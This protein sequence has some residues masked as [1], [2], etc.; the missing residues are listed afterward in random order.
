MKFISTDSSIWCPP[1]KLQYR[2]V[3]ETMIREEGEEDEEEGEVEETVEE[4]TN[5]IEERKEIHE[6][7]QKESENKKEL[8]LTNTTKD[9]DLGL[10]IPLFM[11]GVDCEMCYTEL[12]LEL[13]R[14]IEI[15]LFCKHFDSILYHSIGS[16]HV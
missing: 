5:R 6:K 12:G 11:C 4:K 10:Q 2:E 16:Q 3:I 13:T 15:P 7:T 1:A 8:E 9:A 14:V